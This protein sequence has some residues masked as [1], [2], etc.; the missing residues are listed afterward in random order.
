VILRADSDQANVRCEELR[1]SHESLL[2]RT[3]SLVDNTIKALKKEAEFEVV[4]KDT[5]AIK[6]VLDGSRGNAARRTG[7]TDSE[8]T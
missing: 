6:T 3:M 4:L 8:R 5:E 1:V 2:G 7:G